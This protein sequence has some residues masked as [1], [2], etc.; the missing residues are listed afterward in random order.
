MPAR[1]VRVVVVDHDDRVKR[2]FAKA[3]TPPEFDLRVYD[4]PVAAV[5]E[6]LA[7]DPD[8]LVC[9]ER[10]PGMRATDFVRALRQS[11]QFPDLSFFVLA[12][13]PLSRREVELVLGI[14]DACLVKPV[15]V[16]V[17]LQRL[18]GARVERPFVPPPHTLS[19]QTDRAGLL[20]LMK[21]C[22]DARLTGRFRLEARNEH[23]FVDYLAGTPVSSGAVP[24]QTER[25]PL[26]RL[27]AA[28]GGRYLFE[29]R[30]VQGAEAAAL[31]QGAFATGGGSAGRFSVVEKDGKRFQVYTEAFHVPN[32]AVVTVV[33]VSG[34][35]L[36]KIETLWPHPMKRDADADAVKAQVERQHTSVLKLVEDGAYSPPSRR[37][38]WDLQGGGVE[39]SSLVWVMSLLRDIV[40]A[41]LGLAPTIGLLR[42]SRRELAASHPGLAAFSVD[43][44]GGIQVSL[45]RESTK[46]TLSGV[47][48]PRGA[49]EGVAAWSTVFRTEAGLLVGPPRLPTVRKATR[50]LSD[51]LERVGFYAALEDE[52]VRA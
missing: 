40:A 16:P 26:E 35:G 13:D 31:V 14:H 4:D 30:R 11:G 5:V 29:P 46:A 19:G 25:D 47:R 33:A 45:P 23:V 36:R 10:M 7:F 12:N 18:R 38:I 43:A 41:R 17:L 32:F 34:Q 42:Q 1:A 3:I 24:E 20:A 44:K 50:M 27:I 8:V 2:L 39:G 51:E 21:L 49:I 28:E 37:K 52:R 22:E 9:A 6:L 48:L 15:P